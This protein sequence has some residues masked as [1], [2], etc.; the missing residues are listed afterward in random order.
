MKLKQSLFAVFIAGLACGGVQAQT[1]WDM[2]TPYPDGNFHTKNVRQFA[3]EVKAASG[4]KLEIV[5][6]SNASL[7]KHPEIKRAVQTGQVNIG[8]LLISILSNEN[9]IFAF[10][11][12][13]FSHPTMRR[14]KNCGE[15]RVPTSRSASTPRASSFSTRCPGRR[16]ASTP[17]NR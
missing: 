11:S 16:R 8:E 4:G 7:I 15:S 5:V 14:Q 12:T 9:P 3:D 1:K 13:R 10:D 17:R 6:H 2:P